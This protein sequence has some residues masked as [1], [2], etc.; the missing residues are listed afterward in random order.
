M[1]LKRLGHEVEHFAIVRGQVSALLEEQG[2]PFMQPG[3]YNLILANHTTVV[4]AI[5]QH[6]F[7]I[8]TCHG[9]IPEL[10][11]PSPYADAHVADL[12]GNK[13]HL[14]KLGYESTV[15]PQRHRLRTLLSEAARVATLSTVLSLCQSG[16]G[17]T[18]SY[19]AAVSR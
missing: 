15:I 2:V 18:T 9:T 6:G 17:L 10:E 11:Q 19:A 12:R 1:E 5:H 16:E 8:Q 4:Q 3:S 14:K 7:T 13:G